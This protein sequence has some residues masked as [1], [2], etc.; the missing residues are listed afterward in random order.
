MTK[1]ANIPEHSPFK[2][3]RVPIPG[4]DVPYDEDSHGIELLNALRRAQTTDSD[5]VSG[6]NIVGIP[7]VRIVKR[8]F[9][10]NDGERDDSCVEGPV[11]I[12]PNLFL[13]PVLPQIE[14][15]A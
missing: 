13:R 5:M 15:E 6:T 10:D 12:N 14:P 2:D 7:E 4:I 3:G 8:S 1:E 9:D 11:K